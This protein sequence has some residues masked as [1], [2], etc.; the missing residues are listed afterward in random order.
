[1]DSRP[2]VPSAASRARTL[3]AGGGHVAVV[4]ATLAH[5]VSPEVHHMRADGSTAMLLADDHPLHAAVEM[6]PR[7]EAAALLELAGTR[8][9]GSRL[10]APGRLWITGWL[11]PLSP[12]QAA[13]TARWLA[14]ERPT[15]RLLDV[16]RGASLLWLHATSVLLSDADGV[17]VLAPDELG[18]A[19]PG[20]PRHPAHR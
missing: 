6:T 18:A 16:G 20:P 15:P 3:L 8:P 14:A 10:P 11:R 19:E 13:H 12:D 7:G 1:M 4:A 17:A 5:R 2:S 9:R